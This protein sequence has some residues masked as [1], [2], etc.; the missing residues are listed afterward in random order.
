MTSFRQGTLA[1]LMITV[2]VASIATIGA[3]AQGWKPAAG[4]LMSR[5]AKDVSPTTVH[6]EYPRPQMVREQWSNL[7]GLW[8]FAIRPRGGGRPESFDGKILVPFSVESA[9]SGVM[10]TV[11]ESKRLWYRRGFRAPELDG[12]RRLLLHFGAVD[13]HSTVWVNGRE[14][15]QHR[16]GYDPFS[17]DITGALRDAGEQELVVS[18]WDPTN[19]GYQPRGKQVEKPRGIWYTSVTGIWG[20]VW[21][22]PVSA[23]HVRSLHIVPDIDRGFDYA[24]RLVFL[25]LVNEGF[26]NLQKIRGELAQVIE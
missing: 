18:V 11:G 13:W 4:P 12:D 25:N 14:V 24:E 23:T 3:R 5:F 19:R 16:G 6:Q 26:V 20:T 22:E 7:N 15:G 9:L 8:E 10:K 17:F 2:V 1:P 21:L